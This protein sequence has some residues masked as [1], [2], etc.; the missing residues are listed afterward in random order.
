MRRLCLASFVAC[1]ALA[2]TAASAQPQLAVFA[3]TVVGG[4]VSSSHQVSSGQT[5]SMVNGSQIWYTIQNNGTSTMTISTTS[6]CPNGVW[7]C[8]IPPTTIKGGKFVKLVMTFETGQGGANDATMTLNTNAT[9]SSF[10]LNM[11][12]CVDG[13]PILSVVSGDGI[14]IT[15]EPQPYTYNYPSTPVGVAVSRAFT[16]SDLDSNPGDSPLAVSNYTLTQVEGSCFSLIDGSFPYSISYGS[17]QSYRW[18]MQGDTAGPCKATI[19]F[20]TNSGSFQTFTW[21]LSGT[22]TD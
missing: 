10:V 13:C 7:S 20:T 3:Q 4:N 15:S 5:V 6:F 11:Q 16:I 1:A 14:N 12:N 2:T 18:R 9:P 8:E 19:S 21:I 22:I 17:P